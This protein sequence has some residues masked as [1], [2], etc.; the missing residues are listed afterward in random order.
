MSNNVYKIPRISRKKFLRCIVILLLCGIAGFHTAATS[1]F[2][3]VALAASPDQAGTADEADSDQ[4]VTDGVITISESQWK[5]AGIRI[6]RPQQQAFEEHIRLTGKVALN[7]DRISHIYPMVEGAVDEVSIHLG[8][9]V[10]KDQRLVIVHSREVGQAKLELFQARL[11]LEMA[12]AKDRLQREMVNNTQQLLTALRA[13][14]DLTEIEDQF[15]GKN[16]GDYRERLLSAYAEYVKAQADVTR[17]EEVAGTGAISG[18]QLLA[19]RSDRNA[20]LATYQARIEQIAYET[21][22]S[23]LASLQAVKG[24]S[25]RVAVATTNLRIL[26][27]DESEITS[28]DPLQQGES[29]SHYAIRAPFDGTVI[30]KDV[31]LGEQVRPD[32]QIMTIADLST[33]WIQADIY[34]RDIHLLPSL[35]GS[36]LEFTSDAWPGRTFKARVF[37][38]GEIMDEKTRTVGLRAIAENKNHALKPGMFVNIQLGA[39]SAQPSLQIPASAV[40]EHQG[41]KFVFL[42][43]KDRSFKRR[44]VQ[45]GRT[46]RQW[47]EIIEGLSINDPIV[48]S[49]GFVLKSKMLEALMG[50]E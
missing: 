34:E 3:P 35:S 25:T 6:E 17:L 16:L 44:D 43:Q 42:Q 20:N 47:V 37:F 40:Q 4:S 30:A 10:Q 7:E 13:D 2:S 31:T 49:G 27:C 32:S 22:T 1:S 36:D 21:Q 14:L 50:E 5:N 46:D 48:V 19:A 9:S 26:G 18:K 24:A 33:V 12:E 41:K 8:D 11:E 45:L 38:T 39:T 28:I 29:I 23:L 15:R